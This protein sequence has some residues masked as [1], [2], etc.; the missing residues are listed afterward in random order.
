M[1]Y[2]QFLD[3]VEAKIEFYASKLIK[4]QYKSTLKN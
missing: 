4:K 2:Q 1:V 3:I